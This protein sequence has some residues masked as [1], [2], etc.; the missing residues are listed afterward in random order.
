MHPNASLTGRLIS[1]QYIRAS[2]GNAA[3]FVM[4]GP[5]TIMDMVTDAT[6]SNIGTFHVGIDDVGGHLS[7]M[8]EELEKD[9]IK[10]KQV[11]TGI[12]FAYLNVPIIKNV[13]DT[14]VT[15]AATKHFANFGMDVTRCAPLFDT[16]A[17]QRIGKYVME[18]M[19]NN[20]FTPRS[21]VASGHLIKMFNN[22]VTLSPG[23]ALAAALNVCKGCGKFN[24]TH[25]DVAKYFYNEVCPCLERDQP[26][27]VLIAKKNAA[28]KAARDG[29]ARRH[30]KT[31]AALAAAAAAAAAGPP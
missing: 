7:L 23:N 18:F 6:I 15:V 22:V 24:K 12:Y 25:P 2:I 8:A 21:Y 4:S 5:E 30:A 1:V 11:D 31:Q 14:D 13:A 3:K 19:P 10:K 26:V 16:A 28:K 9:E 17:N 20:E 29:F 27:G